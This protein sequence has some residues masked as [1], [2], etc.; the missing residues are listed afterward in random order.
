MDPRFVKLADLIV[1][2]SVYVKRGELVY[3][4]TMESTPLDMVIAL[5]DAVRGKGGYPYIVPQKNERLIR[6]MALT[7]S[8]KLLKL[9]AKMD[10]T[11]LRSTK[12]GILFRDI[13][14]MFFLHDVP[15]NIMKHYSV[16][17]SGKVIQLRAKLDNWVLSRWPTL[18]MANMFQMSFEE[19]EKLYFQTVLLDYPK[20]AKAVAPLKKLMEQTDMVHI[21][22][23][24]NTDLFFSI[25]GISV[26]PCVGKLNLPD[27]ECFTAPVKNSVNGVI[28]YNTRVI[29]PTCRVFEGLRFVFKNGR[30]IE[31]TCK[32]G[33]KVELNKILD[34]DKGARYIGEFSLGFNP[35]ITD[36]YG[37]PLFDEKVVGSFHF[38]PG[39]SYPKAPNGN[40]SAIHWDIICD[41]REKKGGGNIFFDDKLVRKDGVFVHPRLRQLNPEN[42]MA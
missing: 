20:M 34:I 15:A 31:A 27:G 25:K 10:L 38:T 12:K 32:I 35:Y 8:P 7:D 1:K 33:D 19:L 41:Q 6:Q 4:D 22:G 23:P 13:G 16:Y 42:L 37:E 30:I 36:T 3:I 2:W 11:M 28:E 18:T 39:N 5:A 9:M 21:E 26:V 24:G 40:K 29:S 14:N 17:Y